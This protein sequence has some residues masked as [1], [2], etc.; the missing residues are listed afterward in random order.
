M[1]VNMPMSGHRIPNAIISILA[2][3]MALATASAPDGGN[4][5]S[6]GTAR[7]GTGGGFYSYTEESGLS[8]EVNLWGFVGSPGRYR[9]PASTTLIE[10]ISLA[11]GP[12]DRA[13]LSDIS[14]L[15]DLSVDSTIVDPVSV[16]NLERYQET[17]DTTLNPIL[18]HNDTIVVPGDALN[19]FREILSIFGDIAMVVST[20]T[21]LILAFNR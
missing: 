12:T 10:L 1:T 9:V 14:V 2:F 17:G 16:F 21:A 3:L 15:H 6:G 11:G 5:T 20:A 13:R 18:I 4:T 8:I 7:G 19:V